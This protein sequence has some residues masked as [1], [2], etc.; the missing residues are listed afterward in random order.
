MKKF[1]NP[2]VDA[3]FKRIFGRKMYMR[4]FLNDLLMLEHPI[5]SVTFLDKEMVPAS[6]RN[7]GVV[8]D[9]IVCRRTTSF[10]SWRCS[11]SRINT[12][13]SGRSITWNATL[14][15]S[16]SLSAMKTEANGTIAWHQSIASIC[17]T[18][19]WKVMSGMLRSGR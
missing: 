18:F 9:R 13:K 16:Q 11:I 8:Y 1:M 2:L 6:E 12:L 10:L 19:I 7:H 14:R 17:S 4:E 15:S 3:G 5:K